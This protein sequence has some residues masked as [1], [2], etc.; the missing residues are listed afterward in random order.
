[1]FQFSCPSIEAMATY[2]S[3]KW[4]WSCLCM[5]VFPAVF[6]FF[7][8]C[9]SF[10]L[11][12]GLA[13]SNQLFGCLFGIVSHHVVSFLTSGVRFFGCVTPFVSFHFVP[14]LYSSVRF[15]VCFCLYSVSAWRDSD[16]R[17]RSRCLIEMLILEGGIL[18][19]K[20]QIKI[21]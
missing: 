2:G 8:T 4:W 6:V 15:S 18:S 11:S 3:A 13:G 5:S 21:Y 14:A 9:P 16:G 1:M 19:V 17:G 20:F 7:P 10:H 12:P